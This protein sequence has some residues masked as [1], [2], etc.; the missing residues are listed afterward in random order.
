MKAPAPLRMRV[1]LVIVSGASMLAS[2]SSTAVAA[3][4]RP[5]IGPAAATADTLRLTLDDAVRM[6]LEQG[7]DMQV[8]NAETRIASGR[9]RE[10]AADAWPQLTG[11]IDYTR[12]FDSIFSGAADAGSDSIF[13][14]LL[15]NSP[16]AA[17]KTWKL[18][19][20]GSQTVYSRKVG[21]GVGAARAYRKQTD[22]NRAETAASVTLRV[23]QAYL[24]ASA[25]A[26]LLDISQVGRDQAQAHFQQVQMFR[27]QGT[28][29]EYDLIQAQVDAMNAEPPVV[30]AINDYELAMLDLKR[31]LGIS[32]H[33]PLALTTPLR[34]ADGTV[35]VPDDASLAPVQRAAMVSAEAEVEGREKLLDVERAMRWPELKVSGTVSHQAFPSDELPTRDQFRRSIQG[36][37]R[38]EFPLFLGFKS[39]G[40]IQRATAEVHKA[41]V[42]REELRQQLDLDIERARQDVRRT[43]ALLLARRGTV[44]LAERAHHLANVRYGNGL[45]TQL[46]VTDARYKMLASEGNE[47]IAARDYLAAL[48]QL[49]R[50]LGRPVPVTRR[51][52]DQISLMAP[53]E[54]A[55]R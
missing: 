36:T 12:Q 19:V 43:L 17:E 25:A 33:Q 22:A 11:A 47:V 26:Q 31:V 9:I 18:D 46:E 48:A 2:F 45:S 14:P 53:N 50:A 21:A 20:T 29:A 27:R 39:F 51:P 10:A 32:L 1:L 15:E 35:P 49:E 6:A 23:K 37:A 38:I 42:R 52:I 44:Q 34:F 13:G 55:P 5:A 40:A 4:A 24:T 7:I 41:E 54:L 28:R 16:F 8:A 3:P 30:S